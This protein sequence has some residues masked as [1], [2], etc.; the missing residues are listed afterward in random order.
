MAAVVNPIPP[1]PPPPPGGVPGGVPGPGRPPLKPVPQVITT[2]KELYDIFLTPDAFKTIK[3]TPNGKTKADKYLANFHQLWKDSLVHV[4]AVM[5]P[6]TL[7]FKSLSFPEANI[8]YY[9]RI[10]T[11]IN[12]NP[13][14]KVSANSLYPLTTPIK[15]T[16]Y[17]SDEFHSNTLGMD[18]STVHSYNFG[19][20][21]GIE[22]KIGSLGFM[23][24]TNGEKITLGLLKKFFTLSTLF[25]YDRQTAEGQ[26]V[27][28]MKMSELP[29]KEFVTWIF[30]RMFPYWNDLVTRG[31]FN[32][33]DLGHSP[34]FIQAS[35]DDT[36]WT[37]IQED[38]IWYTVI[39]PCF[40]I[41]AVPYSTFKKIVTHLFPW[42]VNYQMEFHKLSTLLDIAKAL[43]M[44]QS[45][46]SYIFYG[47]S[48]IDDDYSKWIQSVI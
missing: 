25:G 12:T 21:S 1:P 31:N 41:D 19:M 14:I 32:F 47:K 37:I 23:D 7:D 29:W 26:F 42:K 44:P 36:E 24:F 40:R 35:M 38:I 45:V 9:N 39:Y 22:L 28:N 16:P 13:V 3:K 34:K 11:F 4:G 43:G 5:T 27:L 18:I 10:S 6:K 30:L 2:T 46:W 33:I 48:D 17:I 15:P 20:G 8:E